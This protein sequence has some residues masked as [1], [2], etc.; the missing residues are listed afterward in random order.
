MWDQQDVNTESVME[1][2][3][4]EI[5]KRSSDLSNKETNRFITS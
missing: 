1:D 5:V 2:S 3:V 4:M